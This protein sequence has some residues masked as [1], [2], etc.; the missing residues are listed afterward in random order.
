VLIVKIKVLARVSKEDVCDL[1]GKK[2]NQKSWPKK[3]LDEIASLD[4]EEAIN[5]L[6]IYRK[7]NLF[8]QFREPMMFK[9]RVTYLSYVMI[10]FLAVVAVY[11]IRV[12]P[13]FV[14]MYEFFDIPVENRLAWYQGQVIWVYYVLIAVIVFIL[15]LF[16]AYHLRK[17]YKFYYGAENSLFFLYL[18]SPSVRKSYKKVINILGFP[19]SLYDQSDFR[20]RHIVE[21][22]QAVQ[23]S[24]LCVATEMQELLKVEMRILLESCERQMKFIFTFVALVVG[25]VIFVFLFS[26]Y[27][28]IFK[29][30]SML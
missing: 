19:I 23:D 2:L 22:L 16:T 1:Y 30:G 26:A 27:G 21:H 4:N 5:A 29:M 11:Q 20:N 17:V 15:S 10:V 24:K 28:P 7:I 12:A 8:G 14:E 9:K 3:I 13:N 6:N 18:A 25:F